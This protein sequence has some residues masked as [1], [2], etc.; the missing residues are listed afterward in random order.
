MASYRIF[1]GDLTHDTIGL[2]TEV[3]PLNI[4]F[5][6]AY[7]KQQFGDDVDVRLFKYITDLET[8]I[9][10]DP[11]DILA[12][13]NYPWCANINMAMFAQLS[14]RRPEALR[15]MGGPHF[16]HGERDQR[17]FMAA[18]PLVD[19]YIYLDGEVPFAN[20]TALA[21]EIDDLAETRRALTAQ[22]VAGCAHLDGRGQ[23]VSAPEAIRPRELD[24]IPSPYLTGLMDPFFDGRLSPMLQTNRGCP[25]KCTFCHDGTS[26]VNKVTQFSIER[27]RSEIQYI[28]ENVPPNVHSLFISDLN[29]GMYKRDAEIC[30]KIAE[31]QCN[32]DYPR[33]IDTSTG[34]NSKQRVIDNISQLGGALGLTMSVQSMDSGVLTN[35][36]R[37]NIK[38]DGFLDLAPSIRSAK[39]PTISEVILGLPGE[40]KKSHIMG[41]SSLLDAGMDHVTSHGLMLLH[42]SEMATREERE[43]WGFETKFR[44]IQRDFTRLRDGRKVVEIEEIVVATKTMPFSDYLDCRAIN[45]LMMIINNMGFRALLRFMSQNGLK[46]MDVLTAMAAEI[47]NGPSDA[48]PESLVTIM[49]D[50]IA[51]NKLELWDCPEDIQEFFQ[52]DENFQELIEGRY[53]ANLIFTFSA[54]AFSQCFSEVADCVFYHAY[55]VFQNVGLD[56]KTMHM[57]DQVEQ[58]CRGRIHNLLGEDR[59]LTIPQVDLSYDFES[60]LADS[61]SGPLSKF[62]WEKSHKTLFVLSDEQFKLVEDGLNQYGHTDIGRGKLLTRINANTLW[63]N[64]MT[65]SEFSPSRYVA[66]GHVPDFYKV[67]SSISRY[68]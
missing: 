36:K 27:V 64:T 49:D 38:L 30:A 35:I 26:K 65:E 42:G 6:A 39:L 19:A 5:I 23:L 11:P 34:K 48:A 2:A 60:W 25:F 52:D 32:Y 9:E 14:E 7:C 56:E 17:D 54:R 45:L 3:F 18:K 57:L 51:Q 21:M 31:V 46:I 47:G 43:K 22:P 13:S 59:L 28:A 12:L 63:R 55:Q 24:K 33:Y 15:A 67:E 37:D 53:G 44:V 61:D 68:G 40:S 58:F 66:M 41:I 16:P 29:F 20:L 62:A 10:H 50:F 1:F 8:A 4:G